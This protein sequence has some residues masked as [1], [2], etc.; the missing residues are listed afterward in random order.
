MSRHVLNKKPKE[1]NILDWTGSQIWQFKEQLLPKTLV[2]RA[3]S[4]ENNCPT[5]IRGKVLMAWIPLWRE[6]GNWRDFWLTQLY[7]E[8]VD[9]KLNH[10]SLG[11]QGFEYF[12]NLSKKLMRAQM[13]FLPPEMKWMESIHTWSATFFACRH[14]TWLIVWNPHINYW[15]IKGSSFIFWSRYNMNVLPPIIIRL[16]C[17]M[18]GKTYGFM[19]FFI[20]KEA[21]Q[22]QRVWLNSCTLL[23]QAKDS[24]FEYDC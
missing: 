18:T 7:W 10:N 19:V 2:P 14:H 12:F 22:L 5:D 6:T 11:I 3:L 23:L 8:E 15:A 20:T 9:G 17:S 16:N 4:L 21:V 24:C 13:S 1:H